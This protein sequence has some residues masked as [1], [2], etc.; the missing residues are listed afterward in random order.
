MQKRTCEINGFVRLLGII[1]VRVTCTE[2]RSM[3]VRKSMLDH[4]LDGE[5]LSVGKNKS[6]FERIFRILGSV[7]C[8]M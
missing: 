3:G 7:T 1:R 2:D 4:F 5:P 6:T 8:K